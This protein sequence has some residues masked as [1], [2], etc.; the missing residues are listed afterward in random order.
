MK[1]TSA[2][3]SRTEP[4]HVPRRFAPPG[5]GRQKA[6]GERVERPLRPG[7]IGKPPVAGGRLGERL[8]LRPGR[9]AR[10]S[11][12][13]P[14]GD[15]RRARAVRPEALARRRMRDDARQSAGVSTRADVPRSPGGRTGE[16][17]SDNRSTER[18]L[19][20]AP[21]DGGG[22]VGAKCIASARSSTAR[23][24]PVAVRLPF[25]RVRGSSS[26]NLLR[27]CGGRSH[28][29]RR[30]W[31]RPELAPDIDPRQPR[32]PGEKP[33]VSE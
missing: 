7:R 26:I 30:P 9:G 23:P 28:A 13:E 11:T 5:L 1:A 10:Q 2:S 29:R 12:A 14:P 17:G 33:V 16:E 25:S 6:L 31:H 22:A 20:G 18:K 21:V 8:A 4:R 32:L 19:A 27:L 24:F 15:R 3:W